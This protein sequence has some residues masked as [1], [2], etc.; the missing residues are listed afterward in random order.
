MGRVSVE[1]AAACLDQQIAIRV[2]LQ[3]TRSV[4][5]K[6]DIVRACTRMNHEFAFERCQRHRLKR[7]GRCQARRP[8]M[9]AVP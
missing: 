7:A 5:R 6:R 2:E 4:I 1:G 3:R 8:H 9:S